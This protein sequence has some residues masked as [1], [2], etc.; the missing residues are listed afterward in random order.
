MGAGIGLFEL[1]QGDPNTPE[2]YACAADREQARLLFD[3]CKLMILQEQEL[4]DRLAP[5]KNVI[6][7]PALAGQL[8][9]IS[10]DAASKHGANLSAFL[11]DEIHAWPDG[12]LFDVLQTSTGARLQALS[13]SMTT[14]G[15]DRKSFAFQK[16][17]YA[18]K[19]RDGII[20]D[21]AFLPVVYEADPAADWKDPAT[22][23]ACNPSLGESISLDYLERE[24]RR[25]QETPAYENTFKRLHLNIWTES[26]SRWVSFEQWEP[27]MVHVDEKN[28]AGRVCYG[29]L[30][31]S[32]T[33]DLSCMAYVFPPMMTDEPFKVVLRVWIPE[34]GIRQRSRRDRVPYDLWMNQ[35]FVIPTPGAVVDYNFILAQILKDRE[36]FQI[37]EIAFDPWNAVQIVNQLE[38]EGL[39]VFNFRQGMKSMSP[40]AKEF[41]AKILSGQII[42]DN[43]VLTWAL[44]NVVLRL[45]SAGNFMPDKGKSTERIDPVVAVCMC[46]ARACRHHEKKSPY[47][48]RGFLSI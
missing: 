5:F 26:Q 34:D 21:P 44:S 19:V 3:T 2:I 10:S 38:Q 6:K 30:D 7:Y 25:A 11:A 16:Y 18:V 35:G 29:G 27:C 23:A 45:D 31:L 20:Q 33:T 14:A 37:K 13:V 43:P 15:Y 12:E 32:T 48:D 22:W 9:V 17:D 36:H 46:L 40:A 24:C 41:E 42:S 39:P 47:K 4:S 8:K 1:I 28:L